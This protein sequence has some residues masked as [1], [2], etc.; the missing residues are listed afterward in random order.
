MITVTGATGPTGRH[1]FEG[2]VAAGLPVRA[3]VHSEQAV[4]R[5]P[6]GVAETVVGDML[7]PADTERAVAGSD[8]VVHIGRPCTRARSPWARPSSTRRRPRTSGTSC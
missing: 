1:L 8:A 3:L 7:V 6:A 2:L 5:L 4:R